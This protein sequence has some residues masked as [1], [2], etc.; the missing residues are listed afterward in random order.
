MHSILRRLSTFKLLSFILASSCLPGQAAVVVLANNTNAPVNFEI[1]GADGK[2]KP[3]TLDCTDVIPIPAV[4]KISIVFKSDGDSRRYLLNPNTIHIFVVV[5]KIL[6]LHEFL[7]PAP[8]G[9]DPKLPPPKP[10]IIDHGTY[11]IPVKILADDDEPA[12]QKVWEKE[13]RERIAEASDIFERHCGVRFEVKAVDT[14]I[15]DNSI[16]DFQRSIQEFER[17]VNP[18]PTR[19]A[20]GFTSQY[21]I[22]HGLTHLGGTRGPLNPHVLVR[23]WSQYVTR[24]ER[25]EILVH[26]LGHFLGASHTGDPYSV[27]RPKLGDRRSHANSFHIGFDPLNT[28]AMNIIAD[29]LRS[30]Q[31]HGFASMPL[32]T[33][34]Q[35]LRIYL[36][37]NKELPDDPAA[38]VFVDMLRVPVMS[39]STPPQPKPSDLVIATQDVVKAVVEA[40][41]VNSTAM[42]ELKGDAMTEYYIR[43][44]AEKAATHP[45]EISSKV[46]L[47]AMG[48]VLDDSKLWSD[49]PG[50]N[51][52]LREVESDEDRQHRLSVLGKTTMFGRHDL[53]QHFGISCAISVQ[54]NPLLA[55][56]AGVAK[57]LSD[58]QGKSGF[59]FVD[60]S[61]DMAGVTLAREVINGNIT[62]KKIAASFRIRDF[63]P[64]ADDLQENISQ[65]DFKNLYGS[66]ND[67]RYQKV[68]DE[69]RDR[70]QSLPGYK[71]R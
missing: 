8:P 71:K 28:L 43:R 66:I 11:V 67:E 26:E 17:K 42:T 20:I 3:Y 49:L 64:A 68:R 37:L 6:D 44:A 27:M 33:R 41:R 38:A 51:N 10:R 14:W 58:A 25:L 48:I 63:M 24:S 47:L 15:S 54:L 56:Q 39:S 52:F 23:E 34:R 36:A 7:L 30:G 45:S 40:A 62:L 69:I 9:E 4:D 19:V 22:Q 2:Q 16:T 61:A 46:F 18:A 55:E 13:F 35:L 59:S 60:L 5:D 57:E 12:L 21:S 29:E 65:E 32:D 1:L 50:L 53:A 70:I 31:Y